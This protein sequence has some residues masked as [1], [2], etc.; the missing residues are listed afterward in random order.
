MISFIV[1]AHNEEAHLPRTLDALL[2][3]ADKLG[4]PYEV[5]VVNDA[6]TDGT[7]EVARNRGARV[8][9]VAHR[10]IA[11][12]RNAGARAAKGET[13]FFVDADTQVNTA[14]IREAL[15]AMERGA[16]GGGCIFVYDGWI[17]RWARVLLSMGNAVGRQVRL[18]GGACQFCRRADF[19]AVGGYCERY[20]AAEDAFFIKAL[21]R[22]GRVVIPRAAVVTSARKLGTMSLGRALAE[23]FRF[24]VRGP[25][26]FV[27][28]DGLDLWYGPKARPRPLGVDK[29][30]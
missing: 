8:I 18:V 20:F 6:S 24:T 22:R 3:T 25:E 1:P 19:E 5:L 23:L 2:V 14:V 30:I 28:R 10:Q 16:V 13:L 4:R 21:K 26:A 11:T 7:A 29:S 9:D 15:G 27:S 12:T 17:P